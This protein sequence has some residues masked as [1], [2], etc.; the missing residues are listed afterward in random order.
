MEVIMTAEVGDLAPDFTL[1]SHTGDEVTL[2]QYK[3]EKNV[4]IQTHLFSFTGG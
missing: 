2:S 1:R 4:V 3:G